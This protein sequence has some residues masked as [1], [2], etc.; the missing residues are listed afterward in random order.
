MDKESKCGRNVEDSLLNLDTTELEIE[1][2]VMLVEEENKCPLQLDGN[3][4]QVVG[5]HTKV[6]FDVAQAICKGIGGKMGLPLKE[7]DLHR[8]RNEGFPNT[9]EICDYKFWVPVERNDLG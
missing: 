5:V 8:I 1:S 6:K 2:N 3:Q 4:I 7:K 9:E